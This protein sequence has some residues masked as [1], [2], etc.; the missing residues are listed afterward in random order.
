MGSDFL[1]S[2]ARLLLQKARGSGPSP[3]VQN[4][5]SSKMSALLPLAACL[6]LLFL[7]RASCEPSSASTP[8]IHAKINELYGHFTNEKDGG[9]IFRGNEYDEAREMWTP[10]PGKEH[11]W[12]DQCR[13]QPWESPDSSPAK[14]AKALPGRCGAEVD[15]G[16]PKHQWGESEPLG[17]GMK[18]GKHAAASPSSLTGCRRNM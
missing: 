5:L 7:H 3:F 9:L 17:R 14:C 15:D 10:P 8:D 11:T 16:C 1:S 13:F 4:M 18:Y 2:L 6:G 12:Q